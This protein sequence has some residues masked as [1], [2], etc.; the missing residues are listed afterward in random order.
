MGKRGEEDPYRLQ[1][2]AERR[3]AKAARPRK[4]KLGLSKI[5]VGAKMSFIGKDREI[6]PTFS[7]WWKG[8]CNKLSA[9]PGT[10]HE[11][12]LPNIEAAHKAYMDNTSIGD[13]AAKIEELAMDL[14]H[15]RVDPKIGA[16]SIP[17]GKRTLADIA[18][19]LSTDDLIARRKQNGWET[20]QY[21]GDRLRA[22]EENQAIDDE[23]RQREAQHSVDLRNKVTGQD[24]RL[25][26]S[27]DALLSKLLDTAR[28]LD[29]ELAQLRQDLDRLRSFD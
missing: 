10:R 12:P 14:L 9:G 29:R 28:R 5:D 16:P 24:P 17:K 26:I 25:K 6:S 4:R 13:Y 22:I 21:P 1:R 8:L 3:D 19:N 7:V 2:A 15:R 20:N 27:R 23:L 18:K 11:N